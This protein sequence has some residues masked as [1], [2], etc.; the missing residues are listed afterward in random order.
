MSVFQFQKNFEK[1][2]RS[3]SYTQPIPITPTS[4][5]SP[6]K[7][8]IHRGCTGKAH[9][10]GTLKNNARPVKTVDHSHRKSSLSSETISDSGSEV[11][12]SNP[13]EGGSETPPEPKKLPKKLKLFGSFRRKTTDN[14]LPKDEPLSPK[15]PNNR[16]RLL[17]DGDNKKEVSPANGRNKLQH[18]Q[19]FSFHNRKPSADILAS[20]PLPKTKANFSSKTNGTPSSAKSTHE[21]RRAVDPPKTL[22]RTSV[23]TSR[24]LRNSFRAK[25]STQTPVQWST[26]WEQSFCNKVDGGVF[27]TYDHLLQ[28]IFFIFRILRCVL[29]LHPAYVTLGDSIRGNICFGIIFV[30]LCNGYSV[31]YCVTF[32]VQ[33]LLTLFFSISMRRVM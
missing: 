19:S 12:H 8:E 11:S 1:S 30:S 23:G 15:K 18:S 9:A 25:P 29:C 26:I 31:A 6:L 7:K 14:V 27:K 10:C 21:Q 3:S 33:L 2:L 13:S 28:V 16:E 17:S 32:A 4:I 20:T 24:T 5:L 22:T